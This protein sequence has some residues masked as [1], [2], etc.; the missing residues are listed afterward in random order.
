MQ[1][2]STYFPNSDYLYPWW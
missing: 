1:C 2:K